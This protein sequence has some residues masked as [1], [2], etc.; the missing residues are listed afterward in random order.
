MW[1]G[2]VKLSVEVCVVGVLEFCGGPVHEASLATAVVPLIRVIVSMG[3]RGQRH[4][5]Y[6]I[7]YRM[8]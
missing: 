7:L 8:A 6:A 3:S 4:G 5:R 2:V 1:V